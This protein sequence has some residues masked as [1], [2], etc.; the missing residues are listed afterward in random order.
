[1]A[2]PAGAVR[3]LAVPTRMLAVSRQYPPDAV[4][5]FERSCAATVDRLTAAGH[6]VSVL[7]RAVA[8][9]PSDA[10]VQ[11]TLSLREGPPPHPFGLP[12]EIAWHLRSRR[13]A[14][15]ALRMRPDV[16]SL[17]G[18][19]DISA[20]ALDAVIAACPT[21]AVTF[22][23]GLL[24]H[25][26]APRMAV[27]GGWRRGYDGAAAAALRR[28]GADGPLRLAARFVF[29][30]QAIRRIYEAKLGPLPAAVIPH[31]VAVPE[32]LPPLPGR[33]GPLRVGAVGRLVAEKGFDVLVAAA[34]ALARDGAGGT[35]AIEIRG[36]APDPGHHAVLLA[37]AEAARREGARVEVGGPL[38]GPEA[39]AQWMAGKDC[40]A[41]P[42]V[43]EEPF[44]LVPLEAMAAGRPVVSTPTGGSAEL[45]ED[46]VNG[47]VVAPGD[48]EALAAALRRL[49]DDPGLTARLA[50]GG[51]ER[52]RRD[53]R[54]EVRGPELD[55]AILAAAEVR[56]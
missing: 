2:A 20:A 19:T 10:Q 54:V 25:L 15:A 50:A 43:W 55:A 28:L 49:A 37:A 47:L 39:V 44:A 23:Y 5:G 1:M 40:I 29:C 18:T 21:V 6:S 30:S 31:G 24:D 33:D 51:W 14:G 56:A 53:H 7:T 42:A 17:W 13:A 36:T 45:L 26:T 34:A 32:A 22:D 46:G 11:R 4:G 8:G 41:N 16:A 52:V 3:L 38:P 12:R 48:P 35:V 27:R 9:V